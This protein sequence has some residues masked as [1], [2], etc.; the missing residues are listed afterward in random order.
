MIQNRWLK[1]LSY[2]PI[3][4]LINSNNCSIE[5]FT[6]RDLLDEYVLEVDCLWELPV[7]KKLVSKQKED[8]SWKYPL[9]REN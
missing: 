7:P 2:D 4:S 5:Y 3:D 6:R 9:E 8:G 1:D